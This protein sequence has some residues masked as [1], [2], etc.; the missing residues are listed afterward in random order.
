MNTHAIADSNFD[1]EI[2]NSK[3]PILVDF[4]AEW[5]GPCKQI[6]PILEDIGEA[7]KDKLKILKLNIDENPQT[8]QKFGVRGIPT[9]MLFKDGKLVDTKVGSLPKSMLESWLDSNL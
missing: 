8:P 3:I 5:C 7:K 1:E 4:W 6:G 9:L 2:K